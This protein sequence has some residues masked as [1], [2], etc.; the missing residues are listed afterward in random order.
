MKNEGT[1]NAEAQQESRPAQTPAIQLEMNDGQFN[2]IIERCAEVAQWHFSKTHASYTAPMRNGS[3]IAKEIRSLRFA[4]S[5]EG[6]RNGPAATS[7]PSSKW[8]KEL[9]MC[10]WEWVKENCRTNSNHAV[11]VRLLPDGNFSFLHGDL[12][13]D[14]ATGTPVAWFRMEN[15]IRVYYETEAWPNMTPLYSASS[16]EAETELR[17]ERI[18]RA[19][20]QSALNEKERELA[21]LRAAAPSAPAD[22]GGA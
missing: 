15:G 3:E 7:A 11:L 19:E 22:G 16:A 21:A 8:E 4:P 1:I 10:L 5:H 9:A 2:E 17:Q 18:I 14:S 20:L 13:A 12:S 6:K